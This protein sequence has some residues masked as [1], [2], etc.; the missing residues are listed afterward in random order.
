LS[1]DR[2]DQPFVS[3]WRTTDVGLL[4]CSD[5]WKASKH[6]PRKLKGIAAWSYC[7]LNTWSPPYC[8]TATSHQFPQVSSWQ[9]NNWQESP[10]PV[11]VS[12]DLISTIYPYAAICVFD[13]VRLLLYLTQWHRKYEINTIPHRVAAKDL[14]QHRSTSK[15]ASDACTKEVG[16]KIIYLRKINREVQ[17]FRIKKIF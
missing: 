3:W 11:L 10:V 7:N 1:A 5:D 15:K 17:N 4:T 13:C 12:C 16:N 9:S 6:Y 8:T 14:N 2:Q